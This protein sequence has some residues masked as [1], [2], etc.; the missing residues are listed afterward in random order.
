M[1]AETVCKGT[2]PGNTDAQTSYGMV[3]S[4]SQVTADPQ[5]SDSGATS[6]S[7]GTMPPVNSVDPNGYQ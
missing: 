1:A 2:E 6:D 7:T 5:S 4:N 3:S